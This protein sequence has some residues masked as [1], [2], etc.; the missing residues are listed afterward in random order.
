ML[1][2]TDCRLIK[3]VMVQFQRKAGLQKSR[4]LKLAQIKISNGQKI[5][6]TFIPILIVWKSI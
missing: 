6:N 3:Y 4:Q 1:T 2:P 5:S